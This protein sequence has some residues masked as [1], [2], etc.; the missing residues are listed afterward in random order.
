MGYLLCDEDDEDLQQA[1]A[2]FSEEEEPSEDAES[3][4]IKTRSKRTYGYGEGSE[5]SSESN[6]N[7]A[8]RSQTNSDS[9]NESMES[10]SVY[11]DAQTF[12]EC[13]PLHEAQLKD[14]SARQQGATG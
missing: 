2:L 13:N 5:S 11:S 12:V 10:E 3:Y 8:A 6:S 1:E 7:D 14:V 9:L 4:H